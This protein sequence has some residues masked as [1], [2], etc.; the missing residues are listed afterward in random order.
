[1]YVQSLYLALTI[2]PLQITG[3]IYLQHLCAESPVIQCNLI[4]I[5]KS[6]CSLQ[7]HISQLFHCFFF[8]IFAGLQD[9]STST[10]SRTDKYDLEGQTSGIY[11]NKVYMFIA[12]IS[13]DHLFLLN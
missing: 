10:D 5:R 6:M 7:Q 8:G 11:S 9:F 4:S 13:A 2:S 12:S 1:M 3:N